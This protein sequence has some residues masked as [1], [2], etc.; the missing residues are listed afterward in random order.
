MVGT[1]FAIVSNTNT[2]TFLACLKMPNHFIYFSFSFWMV[3]PHFKYQKKKEK[4]IKRESNF[5]CGWSCHGSAIHK[6]KCH[7]TAETNHGFIIYMSCPKMIN[8]CC[9]VGMQICGFPVGYIHKSLRMVQLQEINYNMVGPTIQM[10]FWKT[11]ESKEI[12]L[13]KKQ[14][15]KASRF[16]QLPAEAHN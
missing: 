4:K 1:W 13:S 2:T 16:S 14:K 10:K 11:K 9:G 8:K 3:H 5:L 15:L 12:N 7:W 6:L